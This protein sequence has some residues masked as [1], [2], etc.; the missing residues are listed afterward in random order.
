MRCPNCNAEHNETFCPYCGYSAQNYT[1]Q[2]NQTHQN[3]QYTQYNPNYNNPYSNIVFDSREQVFSVLGNSYLQTF[4][5][6]GTLGKA[7]ALLS[8]KRIYF[9]GKCLMRIGSRWITSK[10]ERVINVEDVTGTG[11]TII[12]QVFL[13]VFALIALLGG[14]S[15]M[16]DDDT[17]PIAFIFFFLGIISIIAYF[18]SKKTIFEINYP[19]GGIAFN[20]KFIKKSEAEDFQRKV[21][22][23]KDIKRNEDIGATI[24]K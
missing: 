11:F 7:F 3:N 18:I 14:L 12:S 13:L 19:G 1:Q 8:D 24:N 6:T 5:S 9:K 23:M 16:F 20:L 15:L 21:M 2:H 17:L 4:I 10:E 22:L